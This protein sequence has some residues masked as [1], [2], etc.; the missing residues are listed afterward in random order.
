MRI[1]QMNHTTNVAANTPT[2]FSSSTPSKLFFTAILDSSTNSTTATISSKIRILVAPFTNR[3]LLSPASSI[4][5]I[6]IVVLDIQSIAAKKSEF[7]LSN[8][9]KRPTP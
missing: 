5:F 8:N 3:A 9:A 4:A 7:M 2:F 1:P 6:T